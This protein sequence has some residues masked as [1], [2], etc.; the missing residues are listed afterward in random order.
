MRRWSSLSCL[1]LFFLLG[2][3]FRSPAPLVYRPGIGWIYEPVGGANWMRLR[4]KDQLDVAQEAFDKKDYSLAKTAAQW[5][6]TQWPRSDYAPKAQY[7]LARCLEE[8]RQDE[9]AFKAYQKL[10]EK[11]PE[12]ANYDEVLQ[13]QFEICNR[14]L[15]GQRFRLWG[16]IPTFPSMEKTVGLYEQLIKNGPY[17]SIAPQAQMNIGA[18]RERQSRFLNDNEP[19][20]QAAKAYELAADRYHDQPQ[21]A[22]D[23]MFREGVAY[24]RQ[25]RTAEY[26]QD[27]AEQ[28]INTLVEFMQRFPDDP[29]VKEAQKLISSLKTEQAHGSFLIAQYYDS[30]KQ[31]RGARI[32]YNEVVRDNPDSPYKDYS[33][34]RI[35]ALNLLIE[36]A[37][38]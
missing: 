1:V 25:A 14:F 36:G 6:V 9:K 32:Y 30:K 15:N 7:L 28:A 5:V 16:Y 17:S 34:Q 27:T 3:A 38:K 13:R 19:F 31:W 23:A 22:A 8:G 12:A 29:R 2:F 35:A 33:L 18:A 21:V 20:E 26:D 11:Y 10:I 4:A 24:E 37:G